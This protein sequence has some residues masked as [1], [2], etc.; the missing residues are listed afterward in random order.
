[1]KW[2][3]LEWHKYLFHKPDDSSCVSWWQ[4]LKCRYRN[5]PEGVWFY[6][7]NGLEPDMSCKRCGDQL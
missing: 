6:N 1:M 2:F 7:I 5:H 4:R 3:S